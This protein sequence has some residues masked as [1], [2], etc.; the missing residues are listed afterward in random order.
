MMK[1]YILT[2]F[3]IVFAIQLSAQTESSFAGGRAAG[4]ANAGVTLSDSWAVFN[5][6]AAMS[7]IDRPVA[8]IF[9]ENRWLLKE[10]GYGALAFTSP[11][12]GGNI[13]IGITNFGYSLFQSNKFSLGFSQQLF[14]NFSMGVMID[15]FSM[16]QSGNYGNLNAINF[17][18][19][20]LSRPTENFAIGVHVFNPLNFS[21]FE[22][23]D[24][25]MPVA[26]KLGFSYLFS[27]SLLIAVETA[28]SINGYVPILRT[29]VEYTVNKQFSFRTGVAVA[30]VEYTF[31]LGY[32]VGDIQFDL[33]YA[34]HEVLGSTPKIS[35]VYAF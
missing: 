34:Y 31:G 17:E 25:K 10:T 27:K 4:M 11:L 21:Y 32:D 30:P 14:Q 7:G 18:I 28:K 2:L 16:R 5:N 3:F 35:I 24:L 1:N 26:F 22:D 20:L 9:Y 13:G 12:L 15:Y 23:A 29:G 8:G 33:A 6:P 19:G